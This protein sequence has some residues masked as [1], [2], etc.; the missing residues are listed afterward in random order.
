MI[1]DVTTHRRLLFIKCV[2]KEEQ[3]RTSFVSYIPKW[4]SNGYVNCCFFSQ[5]DVVVPR[6]PTIFFARMSMRG[7]VVRAS[8]LQG[9]REFEPRQELV[10]VSL[11]KKLNTN[12]S[13]LVG[14]RNGFESASISFKLPAQSN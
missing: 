11:S 1:P 12:C 10:V 8:E 7:P 2:K 3:Y 14:S 9:G 13:V 5:N 6:T 4:H